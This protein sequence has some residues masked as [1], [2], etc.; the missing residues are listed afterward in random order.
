MNLIKYFLFTLLAIALATPVMAQQWQYPVIKKYGGVVAYQHAL[1]KPQKNKEHKV[2][3]HVKS[4]QQKD[5]VNATLWHIAR[6]VNLYGLS[7]VPRKNVHIVAVVSGPATP[8]VMNDD[9][10][11]EKYN[12]SNPNL[13]LI[14]ALHKYGVQFYVCGQAAAEMGIDPKTDLNAYTKLTLSALIDVPYF[15]QKGYQLMQ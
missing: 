4:D 2:L 14:K 6:L 8:L 1:L 10:Y 7:D 5:G 3:F 12:Q 11:R 9:A 13:P 15:E